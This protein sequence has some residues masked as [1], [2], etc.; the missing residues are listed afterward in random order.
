MSEDSGSKVVKLSPVYGNQDKRVDEHGCKYTL[1]YDWVN[2]R[3]LISDEKGAFYIYK[4]DTDDD[5]TTLNPLKTLYTKT[6]HTSHTIDHLKQGDI[7][8][9]VATPIL[10]GLI[11]LRSDLVYE[12]LCG[13]NPTIRQIG[14]F[15]RSGNELLHRSEKYSLKIHEE[16]D[17]TCIK[18]IEFIIHQQSMTVE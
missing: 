11:G 5:T 13:E 16:R 1:W 6:E 7:S 18:S 17:S 8:K 4:R 15:I 9:T 14:V 2:P 10:K 12:M 3:Q